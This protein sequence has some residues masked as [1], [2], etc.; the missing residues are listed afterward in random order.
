[1]WVRLLEEGDKVGFPLLVK[2][3]LGGGG[4]GMKLATS[5]KELPVSTL[6]SPSLLPKLTC[7]LLKKKGRQNADLGIPKR[8]STEHPSASTVD[9][10]PAA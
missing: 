4:K 10:H 1:M 9:M 7:I 6:S 3:V 2:A 5:A 8:P